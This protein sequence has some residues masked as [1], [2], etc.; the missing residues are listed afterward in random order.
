MPGHHTVTNT[1]QAAKQVKTKPAV[2]ISPYYKANNIY[3]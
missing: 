3:I 1:P 2:H